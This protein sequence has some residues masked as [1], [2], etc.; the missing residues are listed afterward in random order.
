MEEN[1][2]ESQEELLPRNHDAVQEKLH[3]SAFDRDSV[4]RFWNR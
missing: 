3:L 4:V 2:Y 1:E